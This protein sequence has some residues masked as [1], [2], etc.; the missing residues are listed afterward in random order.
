M[1]FRSVNR[2]VFGY[3]VQSGRAEKPLEAKAWKKFRF[4]LK[5]ARNDGVKM[6]F[7]LHHPK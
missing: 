1:L 6:I 3:K 4:T 7:L 2:P 5:A